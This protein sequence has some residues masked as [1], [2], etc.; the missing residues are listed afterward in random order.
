MDQVLRI[1]NKYGRFNELTPTLFVRSCSVDLISTDSRLCLPQCRVASDHRPLDIITAIIMLA[2]FKTTQQFEWFNNANAYPSIRAH[3]QRVTD[4]HTAKPQTSF[5]HK[6]SLRLIICR[7]EPLELASPDLNSTT[8]THLPRSSSCSP[9]LS[10]LKAFSSTVFLDVL[11]LSPTTDYYTDDCCLAR[12]RPLTID[13]SIDVRG[14]R[15][16][17]IAPSTCTQYVQ[18]ETT[19]SR[20]QPRAI[21]TKWRLLQD[22]LSFLLEQFLSSEV[23]LLAS[24]QL[25]YV[26]FGLISVS[27]SALGAAASRMRGQAP[28]SSVT[29]QVYWYLTHIFRLP[30]CS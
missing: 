25:F 9:S 18:P 21:S 2:S 26:V 6:I 13:Q 8:Q 29:P 14:R 27:G 19:T 5:D 10:D 30:T 23:R 11:E 3:Q 15:T 12:T 4:D 17:T 22:G 24:F 1:Y 7:T 16:S 28:S 20:W